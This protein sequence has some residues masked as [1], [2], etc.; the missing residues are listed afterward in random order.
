MCS[1][2][3]KAPGHAGELPGKKEVRRVGWWLHAWHSDQRNAA[4]MQHGLVPNVHPRAVGKLRVDAGSTLRAQRT[5]TAASRDALQQLALGNAGLGRPWQDLAA[6]RQLQLLKPALQCTVA[7][8]LLCRWHAAQRGKQIFHG[9][10]RSM[11]R[12]HKDACPHSQVQQ[13][14]LCQQSSRSMAPI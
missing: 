6:A 12:E 14:F 10:L 2:H 9:A 11:E 5:L 8:Q 3:K 13:T 1:G 7:H 4:A